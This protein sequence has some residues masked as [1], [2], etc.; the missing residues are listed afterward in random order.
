MLHRLQRR[1]RAQ[2]LRQAMSRAGAAPHAERRHDAERVEHRERR[3]DR[4]RGGA[5]GCADAEG[6]S[7]RDLLGG[8]QVAQW[9]HTHRRSEAGG[10][11]RRRH[12]LQRWPE[13]RSEA[14]NTRQEKD[15]SHWIV[16]RSRARER[17]SAS[18]VEA[19]FFG[20]QLSN[21]SD[22]FLAL[23]RRNIRVILKKKKK[24]KR[25]R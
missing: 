25:A 16:K 19:R 21:V 10:A 24:K 13:R 22:R 14:R 3:S 1:T 11:R 6:D 9:Q 2:R 8:P 5:Q 20:P 23:Y 18:V 4:G 7:A 15:E 12:R 17:A